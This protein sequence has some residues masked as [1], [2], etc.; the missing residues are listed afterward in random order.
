[1]KQQLSLEA[2]AD[3]CEKQPEG[4]VYRWVDY[5]ECA[6]GQ[7]AASLG[8]TGWCKHVYKGGFWDVANR[9]A[10]QVSAPR[11]FRALAAHLRAAQVHP[12]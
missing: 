12:C 3:W 1:M 7:Y 4:R 11:T 8:I 9:V 6:C 5:N 10:F 2:F